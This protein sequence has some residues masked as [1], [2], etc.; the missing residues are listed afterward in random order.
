[1]IEREAE[2]IAK[3]LD[4]PPCPAILRLSPILRIASL[5]N[6]SRESLPALSPPRSCFSAAAEAALTITH[7]VQ[8]S[9]DWDIFS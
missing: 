5:C 1:M 9:K 2:F 6:S 4:I 3:Q 7:M 8:R